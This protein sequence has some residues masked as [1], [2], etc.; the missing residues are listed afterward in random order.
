MHRHR[1]RSATLIIG[2]HFCWT[3]KMKKPVKRQKKKRIF[4]HVLTGADLEVDIFLS[5]PCVSPRF[6]TPRARS[7]YSVPYFTRN[8]TCRHQFPPRRAFLHHRRTLNLNPSGSFLPPLTPERK[9]VPLILRISNRAPLWIYGRWAEAPVNHG[10]VLFT[11][12]ATYSKRLNQK[13]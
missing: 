9:G 10:R 5:Q 11:P 12:P 1:S 3:G 6:L 4:D 2:F 7:L 13:Y 8:I